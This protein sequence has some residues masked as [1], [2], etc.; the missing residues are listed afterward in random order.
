M[1]K[2]IKIVLATVL[3]LCICLSLSSCI[4]LDDLKAQ[5]AVQMS[6]YE[7]VLQGKSYIKIANVNQIELDMG[8]DDDGY[9]FCNVT[10]EN[11][12][13]LLSSVE[14]YPSE[15]NTKKG[16]I[17]Y[18]EDYYA[19]EDVYPTVS[20]AV[21][22][23]NFTTLYFE[24]YAGEDEEYNTK[25]ESYEI[26]ERYERYVFNEYEQKVI[27]NI[28]NSKIS[29]TES[30]IDVYSCD[31]VL[32]AFSTDDTGLLIRHEFDLFANPNGAEYYL[33]CYDNYNNPIIYIV[34]KKYNV[35]FEKFEQKVNAYYDIY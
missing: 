6:D 9:T 31:Y 13:V 10:K 20:R 8:H 19:R 2:Y 22:Q 15:I 17:C 24:Y 18:R 23:K 29:Y 14:G 32:N 7:I 28:T 11:V 1:K 12:P 3:M 21:A 27:N 16:I 35:I 30:D 26:Y 34:D 4:E 25:Y 33:V 5:H